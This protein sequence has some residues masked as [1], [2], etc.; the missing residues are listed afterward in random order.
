[1]AGLLN[2]DTVEVTL[3][4]PPPLDSPLRVEAGAL[5][6]G[7]PDDPDHPFPGCFVSGPGRDG[8]LRQVNGR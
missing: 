7:G 3:R 1:M 2:A 5:A 8:T 4:L 6:S